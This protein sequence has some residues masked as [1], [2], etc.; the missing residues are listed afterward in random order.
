MHRMTHAAR[1]DQPVLA[2]NMG[3]SVDAMLHGTAIVILTWNQCKQTLRCLQSLADA[4]Y[5]LSQVVLWDN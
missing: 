1:S 4:G 3:G 2:A 5:A